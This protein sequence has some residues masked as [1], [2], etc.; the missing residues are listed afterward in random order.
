M[1]EQTWLTYREAAERLGIS[2]DGVRMRAKRQ[3]WPTDRGNYP[4][5]PV[6]VLVPEAKVAA[7]RAPERAGANVA[8]RTQGPDEADRL[9]RALEAHVE[10]LR[11][12]LLEAAE[13][14]KRLLG[15]L[16]SARSAAEQA[17]SDGSRLL[18]QVGELTDRLDRLHRERNEDAGKMS[19][20]NVERAQAQWRAAALEEELV[21]LKRRWWRRIFAGR[22][23]RRSAGRRQ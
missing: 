16:D 15:E 6:R 9:V 7:P 5:A 10:T 1:S 23:D 18:Q 20:L 17:R 2:V 14:R 8:G 4:N 11:T 19:A 3:N 12:Q 22:P 13:E 21:E